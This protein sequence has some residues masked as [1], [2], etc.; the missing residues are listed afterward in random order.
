MAWTENSGSYLKIRLELRKN[1]H[2]VCACA[3]D[4]CGLSVS[5]C[6][7]THIYK[8]HNPWHTV[9]MLLQS[10]KII[11]VSVWTTFEKNAI[12]EAAGSLI[13][14]SSSPHLTKISKFNNVNFVQILK[15]PLFLCSH[16][17]LH[18]S[19]TYSSVNFT[20]LK[21]TTKAE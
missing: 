19:D 18:L 17:I 12:F 3:R 2:A 1:R 21:L 5:A 4:C 11:F 9:Y 10:E 15:K 20:S 14:V 6:I 16:N 7:P 8:G 13:K